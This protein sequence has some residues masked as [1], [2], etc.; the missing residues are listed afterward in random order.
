MKQETISYIRAGYPG[1]YLVSHEEARAEAQ[2]S[3]A[4]KATK[5]GLYAWSATTGMIDT[6]TGR[7]LGAE[8]PLA[9][10]T[11]IAEIPENTLILLRNFHLFLEDQ[12][13][14][15]IRA[16]KDALAQ[17]KTKGKCIVILGCS[18]TLQPELERE[19]VTV[20][21]ALPGK[22]E[23]GV[24]LD[25]I[26]DS[27]KLPKPKDKER[28]QILEAASG[29]T[30]IEAENAFALSI[31]SSKTVKA[32]DVNRQKTRAIKSNGL[33]E[34]VETELNL[35]RI[36]GLDILKAW[37]LKR[38][39][40]FGDRA[41]AYGLPSPK[42][43]LIVGVPGTGKSLTAKATAAV[44]GRPLLK[45]DAGRLFG[46]LVGQSEGNLRSAIQTAEAIAP[47]VLWIDEL[48]KAFA[49]SKSSGASDGGTGARVFG[50]FLSWMQ[51]KTSQVFVIATGNDVT[52]LPAEL[53]RRG[54]FDELFFTDLPSLED[55]HQIWS[56]QIT[57]AGRKPEGFNLEGLAT[58]SEGFTGAEIEQ[59]V[60]DALYRAFADNREPK[61]A[62]MTTAICET[63]PLSKLMSEQ[64]DGLRKW[65]KGR[66]RMA[67]AEPTKEAG[68]RRIAA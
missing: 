6:K 14:V 35:D 2:L 11:A 51:E 39:S 18:K 29:L 42:G 38:S 22:D 59:C 47:C 13:P 46:S 16:L 27:A 15:L 61:T 5:H 44:F 4:A 64:I 25:G 28:E 12:N 57:K 31:V 62:D 63:V 40:A 43:L 1:I 37:L 53:L 65:A 23:L 19:F 17:A 54:R 8:D 36:G 41:K 49:G 24:V 56:I 58:A 48:E 50:A 21:M 67:A 34:V 55:R 10:L 45:L 26:C 33:L 30:S 60:Q 68:V 3:E 7:S 52:Q 32:S 66:C 9:A 20:E